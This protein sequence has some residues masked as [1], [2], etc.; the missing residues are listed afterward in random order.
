MALRQVLVSLFALGVLMG[1][2]R[3]EILLYEDFEDK[4]KTVRWMGS[5]GWFEPKFEP[6]SGM[7]LTTEVKCPK[8][9]QC[10]KYNIKQG[11][12]G[13]GGMFHKVKPVD[14]MHYRY[15]RMFPEGWE[16]PKGYGPH[17]GMIFGGKWQ[18]PTHTDFSLYLDFW[19]SRETV[20]RV[21]TRF[22]KLGY[23][24]WGKYMRDKYGRAPNGAQGFPYN[25]S[26]PD[27]IE[28]GKWHCVEFMAKLSTP[29]KEDGEVRLWVNGKLVSEYTDVPLRDENH[30]DLKMDMVFMAPYFHPGSPKDQTHYLDEIVIS[31]EYIGPVGYQKPKP[32]E[33]KKPSGGIIPPPKREP[34]IKV[35]A[36]KEAALRKDLIGI[37]RD[38]AA[39]EKPTIYIDFAGRTTRAKL[40]SADYD[41]VQVSMRGMAMPLAWEKIK[42]HR[43]Y[44]MASK[45]TDDH[46]FLADYC[47]AAGLAE[48]LERERAAAAEK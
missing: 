37:I 32:L 15:Y 5:G 47:E 14:K 10:V 46:K 34:K 29:G 40:V 6:G 13:S 39:N 43:L 23:G 9:Q 36:E 25:K 18:S 20:V 35:D 24:G 44:G 38:K 26:K 11:K 27:L 8:G 41:G 30:P 33:A 31:T 22:Q 28:S 4:P 19:M 17:D 21:A 2:A 1:V 48:E 7:E 12:K 45:L 3:G 42:P 16:W